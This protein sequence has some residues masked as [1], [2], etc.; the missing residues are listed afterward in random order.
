MRFTESA[1][2]SSV[3][4]KPNSTPEMADETGCEVFMMAEWRR[5]LRQPSEATQAQRVKERYWA[6]AWRSN[7]A[8]RSFCATKKFETAKTLVAQSHLHVTSICLPPL[9]QRPHPNPSPTPSHNPSPPC[10]RPAKP[11]PYVPRHIPRHVIAPRLW[12]LVLVVVFADPSNSLPQP[13]LSLRDTPLP[14]PACPK[15]APTLATMA[16]STAQSAPS[17][18]SLQ[19]PRNSTLWPPRKRR[20]QRSLQRSKKRKL[21]QTR[22]RGLLGQM[23]HRNRVTQAPRRVHRL[24]TQSWLP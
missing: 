18:P 11:F 1:L 7:F 3:V 12:C 14:S 21:A 20:P 5:P 8:G 6:E 15:S 13:R 22:T 24:Q 4:K 2:T 9:L 23:A 16:M 19:L 10:A 17:L